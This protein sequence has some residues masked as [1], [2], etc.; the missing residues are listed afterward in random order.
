MLRH[1]IS[2]TLAMTAC[3]T[4]IPTK[5]NAATLSITPTGDI[6]VNPGEFVEFKLFFNPAPF[7]IVK[8]LGVSFTSDTDGEFSEWLTVDPFTIG[9]VVDKAETI[10]SFKLKF[11]KPVKD[12]RSDFGATV[13][14]QDLGSGQTFAAGANGG[15]VVPV[16]EPLTIFGTAT[17]FGCGVLF[18]RK[19]SKKT[20][21]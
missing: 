12:G 15:D 4:L 13:S 11:D 17:A 14:Y 2:V 9:D 8:L 10:A 21:F 3:A 6:A 1:I 19:S 20:V 7:S 18:K 16:P 5:V